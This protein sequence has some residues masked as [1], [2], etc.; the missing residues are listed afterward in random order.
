M[1]KDKSRSGASRNKISGFRFDLLVFEFWTEMAGVMAEGAAPGSHGE[2][3]WK[4]GFDDP[5]RDI[6]NHIWNHWRQWK[7]GD[8]SEPH[9][10][11]MAVGLMFF[12]YFDRKEKNEG[13]KPGPAISDPGGVKFRGPCVRCGAREYASPHTC[14]IREKESPKVEATPRTFKAE[15]R[16]EEKDAAEEI[17]RKQEIETRR[18]IGNESNIC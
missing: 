4:G 5:G 7:A 16:I 8:R 12:W 1:E 10:A 15:S 9:L 17:R 3:N 13:W 14:A 18:N 11:K 2:N 6:E